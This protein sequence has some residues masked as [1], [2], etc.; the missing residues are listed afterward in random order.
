[1]PTTETKAGTLA[2]LQ[3]LIAGLQSQ[4]PNES[5]TL[6]NT[7]FTTTSLVQLLQEL[8]VAIQ[9]V[10]TAQA[11]ARVA[12][13][14]MRAT[15]AKVG[16]VIRDLTS[17]LVTRFGNASDILALFDMEPRK[18]PTPRTAETLAAAKAK[19]KATRE[20]RGTTS[21]KQKLT[22]KGNVAG[23]T[24]TPNLVGP[25]APEPSQLATPAPSAPS[26]GPAK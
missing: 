21:K 26:T 9:S 17:T 1:M 22:V 23:V 20:A 5:F 8:I 10:N 16:P 19:A 14:N 2:Q 7:V 24:V 3:G 18:V 25:L 11:S 4:L 13:S 12:V 15:K 6:G